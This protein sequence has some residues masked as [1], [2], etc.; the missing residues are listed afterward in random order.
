MK[1]FDEEIVS[2]NVLNSLW[3]LTWPLV[4]LNLIN[5]MHGFIDQ[6]LIGHFVPGKNNEGNAAVGVA[7]QLFIVMV[8]LIASISHGMNVLIARYAGRQNRKMVNTIFFDAFLTGAFF[9][10]GIV[11]PLGYIFSPQLLRFIGVEERVY[12]L[13]L[14]YLR[15][16]FVFNWTLFLMILLTGAFQAAGEPKLALMLNILNAGLNI[17]ISFVLITGLGIFPSFGVIGAGIGTVLAPGISLLLAFYLM[18]RG[19]TLIQLPSQWRWFP[20]FHVLKMIIRVGLPTGIQGVVLNIA[21]VLLIKYIS[22]MP[23]STAG[24]SAYTIC[25]TQLFSIVTWTSFGLRSACSTVMGQNIGAG[26]P[27]RGKKAVQAGAY[28]GALW[29]ATI[30]VIFVFFP[31]PLLYIF[32]AQSE[33]VLEYGK[34][35]LQCLAFSGILLSATLAMTGGIQG[36]GATRLPMIIAMVSQ[37]GVL[38]GVCEVLYLLGMLNI[39]RIWYVILLAHFVRYVLT[40]TIFKTD[41]WTKTRVEISPQFEN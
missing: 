29:G 12:H 6:V 34:A 25:Y 21:G 32:N 17:V 11:A 1:H 26:N 3:K 41:G 23:N 36:S 37:F 35:L 4:L 15:L 2:G 14:P 40:L 7:W 13:S 27:Q 9:L 22:S 33:L 30:G 31:T 39:Y 10:V 28:L 19:K 38:L 5:G 24:Q 20:N 18:L 16:L 8:V